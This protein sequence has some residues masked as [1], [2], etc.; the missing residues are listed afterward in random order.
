M[1]ARPPLAP[2]QADGPDRVGFAGIM[3]L[4]CLIPEEWAWAVLTLDSEFWIPDSS[5]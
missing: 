5:A 1:P 2:A 3:R 4:L